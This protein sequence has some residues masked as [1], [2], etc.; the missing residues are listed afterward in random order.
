MQPHEVLTLVRI[1]VD[2][3]KAT[4]TGIVSERFLQTL[5]YER[6]QK[7]FES[8][9]NKRE[10]HPFGYVCEDRGTI[11][12]F[13]VAG[14]AGHSSDRYQG[15]LHIISV[16]P[17]YHRMGIGRGL[18]HAV[19]AHFEREGVRSMFLGVFTDNHPARRFY[20]ALGGRKVD[21][22]LDEMGGEP[23]MV[24]TY[25]WSSLSEFIRLLETSSH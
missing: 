11:V 23:L 20:E 7:R 5:S 4:H 1:Y 3:F 14:L 15:E 17:A 25:G 2:T 16:S 22:G 9:F 13:A 10:R 6:A 8:I 21:E 19:A 18:I 24:T 12:G